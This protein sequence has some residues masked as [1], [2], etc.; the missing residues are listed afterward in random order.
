[1]KTLKEYIMAVD[2][3]VNEHAKLLLEIESQFCTCISAKPELAVPLMLESP[4]PSL[5]PLSIS[6]SQLV[7]R[8]ALALLAGVIQV[9][10]C[11]FVH[12]MDLWRMLISQLRNWVGL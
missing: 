2:M 9:F 12:G 3:I 4:L 6:G 5:S 8:F 1:M 10:S 11:W 7:L